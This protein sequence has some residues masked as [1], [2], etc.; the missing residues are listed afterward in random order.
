MEN[1]NVSSSD[2]PVTSNTPEQ[3][4]STLFSALCYVGPL[5]IVS[6]ALAK[7]DPKVKY[8]IKQGLVLIVIEA[9]VWVL[10]MVFGY[11]F[12]PVIQIANLA[13]IILSIIGIINALNGKE[14]ELPFV[15]QFSSKF[16]NI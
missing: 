13:T 7:D 8:H 14:K 12:S 2:K 11:A 10:G 1:D 6:Y 5:I 16:N 9:I 3:N 15:G 4:K